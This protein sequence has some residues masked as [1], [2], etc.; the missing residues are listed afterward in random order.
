MPEAP[1][2]LEKKKIVEAYLK[3][4]AKKGM[5]KKVFGKVSASPSAGV[6]IKGSSELTT[7]K[8]KIGATY[9]KMLSRDGKGSRAGI[10]YDSD[11]GTSISADY[12]S[13][14]NLGINYSSPR[15]RSISANISKEN[16]SI[17]YDSPK[18]RASLSKTEGSLG[19][20]TKKGGSVNIG[21][22][23]DKNVNASYDSP[24]GRSFSAT[25]SPTEKLATGY[26]K[27]KKGN[28]VR[29]KYDLESKRGQVSATI[30]IRKRK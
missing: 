29:A 30:P 16:P 27:S 22:D 12:G 5:D 10:S 17:S 28:I 13:D 7:G 26:Y 6:D 21:A 3:G 24:G 15:G 20:N 23:I 4:K 19:F 14:K 11:K 9:T 25:Y 8:G 2:N 1:S 18:L